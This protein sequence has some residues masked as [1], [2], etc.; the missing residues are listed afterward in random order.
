MTPGSGAEGEGQL[1]HALELR[2][3]RGVFKDWPLGSILRYASQLTAGDGLTYLDFLVRD[4]GNATP[5]ERAAARII[6]ARLSE[7]PQ[8]TGRDWQAGLEDARALLNE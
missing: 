6:L 5:A 7:V 1:G 8:L 3:T 2:R 4:R